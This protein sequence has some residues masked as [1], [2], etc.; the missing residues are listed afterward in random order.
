M[1]LLTQQRPQ[2][3]LKWTQTRLYRCNRSRPD[4]KFKSPTSKSLSP[5]RIATTSTYRIELEF[6]SSKID[7]SN[8]VVHTGLKGGLR[9]VV[10]IGGSEGTGSA[11]NKGEDSCCLHGDVLYGY[12]S[13]KGRSSRYPRNQRQKKLNT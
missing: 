4:Y 1:G 8:H 5:A 9:G 7:G 12:Y 11:G 13:G 6:L 3:D 10:H 2:K